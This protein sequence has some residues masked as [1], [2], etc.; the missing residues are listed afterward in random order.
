MKRILTISGLIAAVTAAPAFAQDGLPNGFLPRQLVP[1]AMP[2]QPMPA[3]P[4]A[5]QKPE[6]RFQFDTGA[7]D[8]VTL[9]DAMALRDK[10]LGAVTLTNKQNRPVTFGDFRLVAPTDDLALDSTTCLHKSLAPG[11]SCV[12][13]VLWTPRRAGPLSAAVIYSVRDEGGASEQAIM[14]TGKA[15]PYDGESPTIAAGDK[16]GVTQS[17]SAET[18]ALPGVPASVLRTALGT[19]GMAPAGESSEGAAFVAPQPRASVSGLEL[20]GGS[21]RSAIFIQD[22]MTVVAVV[23]ED[24]RHNGA[25]LVLAS[26][27]GAAAT[28]RDPETGA[29]YTIPM[30]AHRPHGGMQ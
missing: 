8:G 14:L 22:G 29:T 12:A 23:G 26:M 5:P 3:Q 9:P 30:S 11:E 2:A 1:A 4:Q 27:D 25:S 13:T 15:A 18:V 6:Q 24:V 28:L 17:L 7:G 20:I 10:L 19:G 21:E 16:S